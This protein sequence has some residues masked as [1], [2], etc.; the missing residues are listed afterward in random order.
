VRTLGSRPSLP[1]R[2]AVAGGV[3]AAIE[4]Y[5]FYLYGTAAALV[6]GPLYFPALSPASGTLAALATFGVGFVARPLGALI[7]G[8][9]GDRRGRRTALVVTVLAMGIS[10]ALM[11]LLPTHADIGLWAPLLLVLLR[12]I[13]GLAVGGDWG[14]AVT[15]V[16]EHA[17]AASRALH[18]SAPQIGAAVGLVLSATAFST[19]AALSGPG[20]LAWG[21]RL[22]FLLSSVLVAVGLIVR[23]SVPESPVFRNLHG[24]GAPRKEPHR[25]WGAVVRAACAFVCP[26]AVFYM[27]TV[28]GLAY[29][30]TQAEVPHDT[31]LHA[32]L[33]AAAIECVTLPLLGWLADRLGRRPVYGAGV[34][35]TA[36]WAVPAFGLLSTGRTELVFLA[37]IV[38][39]SVGHAAQY[40]PAAAFFAEMFPTRHRA[41]GA[42]L[43]YH[44][45]AAVGGGATPLVAAWLVGE[46]TWWPAATVLIAAALISLLGVAAT[47]ETRHTDLDALP[48][49][50]LEQN[51]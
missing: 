50:P 51:R 23:L 11:G 41:T 42:S 15:L 43:G 35:I 22:P 29:A 34:L 8:S 39:I 18:G 49:D 20:F 27:V 48:G 13:Q 10:T 30:T 7:L 4:W 38:A 37:V 31:F 6:L 19:A 14:N 44:L 40:A 16:V 2:A 25:Q 3:G 5:D 24:A 33:T 28:F 12:F 9:L 32:V 21:W 36:L 26:P 46:G 1:L 17:P 45:G 47:R